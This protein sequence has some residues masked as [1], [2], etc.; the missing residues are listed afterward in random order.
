MVII[1]RVGE[2]A[3]VEQIDSRGQWT[4]SK[5]GQ[6]R[7][8]GDVRPRSRCAHPCGAAVCTRGERARD[9]VLGASIGLTGLEKTG[10][11]GAKGPQER[12]RPCGGQRGEIQQRRWEEYFG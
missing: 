9:G 2:S 3:G 1:S 10:D 6:D 5:G 11:G 12:K 8:K 4:V 7:G